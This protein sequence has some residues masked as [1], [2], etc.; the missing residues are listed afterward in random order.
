[1][2]FI[3]SLVSADKFIVRRGLEGGSLASSSTI[4]PGP[5]ICLKRRDKSL[6]RRKARVWRPLWVMS[7]GLFHLGA[8]GRLGSG[9]HPFVIERHV[10]RTPGDFGEVRPFCRPRHV[11]LGDDMMITQLPARFAMVLQKP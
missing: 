4:A 8:R 9:I 10:H 5:G 2:G 1:M 3:S 11:D 7:G 6:P